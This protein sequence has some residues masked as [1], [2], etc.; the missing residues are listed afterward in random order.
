[1]ITTTPSLAGWL[2]LVTTNLITSSF[3]ALFGLGVRVRPGVAGFTR[4]SREL[5][6]V[7]VAPRL[8]LA[9][10]FRGFQGWGLGAVGEVWRQLCCVLYG[11]EGRWGGGDEKG[12]GDG[13]RKGVGGGDGKGGGLV[14]MESREV[15]MGRG[16]SV[17]ALG[18]GMGD[19]GDGLR[20]R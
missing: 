6:L 20:F 14:V 16:S 11:D 18:R 19:G 3:A 17:V 5:D 12:D 8:L 1:M 15:A 9:P 2:A 10:S 13:D 4:E 7:V